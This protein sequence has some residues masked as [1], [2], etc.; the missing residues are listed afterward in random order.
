[1]EGSRDLWGLSQSGVHKIG[2]LGRTD[3]ISWGKLLRRLEDFVSMS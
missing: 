3:L 1:M 2:S